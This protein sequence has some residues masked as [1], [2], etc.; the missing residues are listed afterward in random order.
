MADIFPEYG[1]Y[2]ATVEDPNITSTTE[3]Q[4]PIGQP[5][6]GLVPLGTVSAF[7]NGP[8][9]A[10]KVGPSVI[11]LANPIEDAMASLEPPTLSISL[12]KS[13]L[14]IEHDADDE[15]LAMYLAAAIDYAEVFTRQNF[16]KA[17]N[18]VQIPPSVKLALLMLAADS[19][20]HRLA[21]EEFTL[22]TNPQVD[23]MLHQYRNY[24][25]SAY[26]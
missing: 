26:K 8:S 23:R 14:R 16:T 3:A 18:A 21:Q 11:P 15:I 1:F 22:V 20:E 6:P 13:Q 9:I 25:E 17:P 5:Y 2:K 24:D 7:H 10:P 4:W 19:Y 12:L